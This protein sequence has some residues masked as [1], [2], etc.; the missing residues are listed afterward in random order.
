LHQFRPDAPAW[1]E[2]LVNKLLAKTPT[3][4]APSAAEVRRLLEAKR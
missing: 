1:L 3:A 2:A 4:R